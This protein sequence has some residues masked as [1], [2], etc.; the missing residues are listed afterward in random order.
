MAGECQGETRDLP[1]HAGRRA[2]GAGATEEVPESSPSCSCCRLTGATSRNGIPIGRHVFSDA[3]PTGPESPM[4]SRTPGTR[5]R[6]RLS[7]FRIFPPTGMHG[8]LRPGAHGRMAGEGERGLRPGVLHE[9]YYNNLN[10]GI[11]KS[12]AIGYNDAH[13]SC[14]DK[15][16]LKVRV[17]RDGANGSAQKHYGGEVWSGVNES[18]SPGPCGKQPVNRG[19]RSGETRWQRTGIGAASRWHGRPWS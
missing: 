14:S 8:T 19:G 1:P 5:R 12:V 10:R 11:D 16:H 6:K 4:S 15:V 2:A 7:S 18:P 17:V 9:G 3:G 13:K